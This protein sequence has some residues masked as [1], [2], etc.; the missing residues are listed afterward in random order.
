MLC[1]D[2]FYSAFL[3]QDNKPR[4][5]VEMFPT[6]RLLVFLLRAKRHLIEQVPQCSPMGGP[7]GALGGMPIGGGG[8]LGGSGARGAE[9]GGAGGGGTMPGGAGGGMGI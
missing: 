6:V 5:I 1:L 4:H 2:F 9:P 3:F 8:M 7:N